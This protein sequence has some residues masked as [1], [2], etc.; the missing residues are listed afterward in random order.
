LLRLALPLVLIRLIWRG[1]RNSNYWRRWPERFGFVTSTDNTETIWIH[2]VSVGEVRAAEPLVKSLLH[3][4]PDH[5]IHV[6]TMTPTGSV[7]VQQSFSNNVS[8]CYVPYDYPA[9]VRRFIRR[10]KPKILITMETELWPN[11]F[12]ICQQSSVPV[13]VANARMSEKSML[14]YQRYPVLTKQTLVAITMVAAQTRSDADR[15]EMLGLDRDHIQ[16][17]GSIKFDMDVSEDVLKSGEQ[18]RQQWGDNRKIWI[19]A[20]THDDEEQRLLPVFKKLKLQFPDLLLVVVPRHPE[21]FDKVWKLY[22]QSSFEVTRRSANEDVTDKTDILLGDTMG[23]LVKFYVASDVAFIGGSLVP[24][25]GQNPLEALAVGT[26]VVFGPSMHN[27]EDI[28][29]RILSCDAGKQVSDEADLYQQI[30][31][32]LSDPAEINRSGKNGRTMVEDNKGAIHKI[33]TMVETMLSL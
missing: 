26:P 24:H 17:T 29:D 32:Y 30:R 23:E 2:A 28:K 14:R 15:I 8:H 10:I 18:L 5:H 1:F 7:Q 19:A 25:G 22:R 27:F 20:S 31:L 9:S 33:E 3:H 21:R 16:V 6:T 4:Y 13:L 12:S 11:M